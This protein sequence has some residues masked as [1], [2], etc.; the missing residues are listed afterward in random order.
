MG[1][2]EFGIPVLL[3]RLT[4]EFNQRQCQCFYFTIPN[5]KGIDGDKELYNK[6]EI[7]AIRFNLFNKWNHW[8][9]HEY[10]LYT[11]V[12]IVNMLKLDRDI[13]KVKT[14]LDRTGLY[15]HQVESYLES[16]READE[17][18]GIDLFIVWSMRLRERTIYQYAKKHNIPIYIFEH[19]YFR[20]FTLTVDTEGINFENSLPRSSDFYLKGTFDEERFQKYLTHPEIAVKDKSI[21]TRYREICSAHSR[22]NGLKGEINLRTYITKLD[23]K[24][25]ANITKRLKNKYIIQPLITKRVDYQIAAYNRLSEE[26]IA[27]GHQYIFVPFQL[28]TDTQT[29]LYSPY[30]KTMLK[31]VAIMSEAVAVYNSKYQA[32]LNVVF[33]PHPMYK[34]KEPD[35]NMLDIIG[36]CKKYKN[37]YINTTLSTST[38]INSSEFVATINSTVGIEALT[39]GKKVMTLGQA[40]YNIEGI[41][42]NVEHPD[43]LVDSIYNTVHNPRN[44][45]LIKHFLYYIRFHYFAEIFYLHPDLASVRRLADRILDNL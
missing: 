11:E 24:K 44:E 14:G 5:G 39:Q 1:N 20:P 31:L 10:R 15:K 38:L 36:V 18:F 9:Y 4:D 45:E 6:L 43:Q 26:M 2:V 41:V 25:L 21:T 35:L 30:I 7:N 34:V 33:K 12:E 42:Q 22:S 27:L 13:E 8:K 32:K 37:C 3:K 28:Q 29:V 23:K 19:G 16:I 40:F 17:L